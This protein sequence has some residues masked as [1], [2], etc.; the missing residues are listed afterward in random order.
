MSLDLLTNHL[1]IDSIQGQG[2]NC[3]HRMLSRCLECP[4]TLDAKKA[5][6]AQAQR[7]NECSQEDREWVSVERC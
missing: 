4:A 6:E 1:W 2:H 3:V 7:P 5:P